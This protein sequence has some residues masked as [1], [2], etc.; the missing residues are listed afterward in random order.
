MEGGIK[1]VLETVEY[2]THPRASVLA[3]GEHQETLEGA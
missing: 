1:S 3:W 2:C